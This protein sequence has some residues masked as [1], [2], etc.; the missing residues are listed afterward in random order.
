MRM[1]KASLLALAASTLLAGCSFNRHWKAAQQQPPPPSELAGPWE[2]QWLSDKNAHRGRLRC[3]MTPVGTNSY[4]AR[5]HATFWK[6]F[7]ASYEVPFAVTND[8]GRFRFSGESD[9]GLLGGGVYRY[10]GA[11]DGEQFTAQYR[12]K[13]DHGTFK[14]ER[15]STAAEASPR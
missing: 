5:F 1:L 12:S 2:G 3:I 15:P 6:I 13:H 4:H 11:S 14:M 8:H 10:T 9:L 7:R